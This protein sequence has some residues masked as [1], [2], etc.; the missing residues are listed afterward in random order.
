MNWIRVSQTRGYL[1]AVVNAVM[2]KS[3]CLFLARQPAVGQVLLIHEVSR[4]HTTTH[5]SR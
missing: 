4:L 1:P 3:V 5:H 2:N